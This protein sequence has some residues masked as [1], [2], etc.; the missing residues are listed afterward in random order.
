MSSH[1]APATFAMHLALLSCISF[2]GFPSVLP[3]IHDFVATANGWIT[4]QEFANFFALAQAV[5]G[6]NMILLMSFIGWKVAGVPGAIVSAVATFGPPC[7]MYFAAHQL[8]DGFRDAAWQ[9][10]V[11]R[12]LAPLTIGLVIAGGTVMARDRGCRVAAGGP[13]NRGG[14]ADDPD[15]HQP[16]V[17]P[18]RGRCFR[19]PR[20]ALMQGSASGLHKHMPPCNSLLACQRDVNAFAAL[21]ARP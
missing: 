7:A 21:G 2:G 1:S 13:D 3:D 9:K 8:W 10:I 14:W 15:T 18:R 5:P 6:P 20:L 19:R 11:R 12:G 4:D 17:G 16:A